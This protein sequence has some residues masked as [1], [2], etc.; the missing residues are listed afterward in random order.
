MFDI[1]ASDPTSE[2]SIARSSP[3]IV[4]NVETADQELRHPGCRGRI[5]ASSELAEQSNALHLSLSLASLAGRQFLVVPK[6]D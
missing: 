5:S 6:I 4:L 3:K 2:K 1:L